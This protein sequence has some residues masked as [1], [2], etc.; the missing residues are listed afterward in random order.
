VTGGPRDP[1]ASVRERLRQRLKDV[2]R[3]HAAL[4][5]AILAAFVALSA[6]VV[7]RMQAD[8]D[9]QLTSYD[10][11]AGQAIPGLR[12]KGPI[13]RE[14][15]GFI[16]PSPATAR[17]S[18]P[19]ST[20]APPEGTRTLLL[21][22]AGG[23][24]GSSTTLS[25]IDAAGVSHRL[26]SPLRWH[27]RHVDVTQLL[28]GGGIERL[29]FV[30]R[31]RTP[32]FQQMVLQ[33]R[34][35]SYSPS[36]VPSASRWEIG[37]WVALALAAALALVGR[38]RRD[39]V[40]PVLAGLTAFLVWP[41][42]EAGVFQQVPSDLWPSAVHAGW[43]DLDT[44]LLSG[45]FGLRSSLA[46]QLFHALTPLTGTGS[47]GARTA[48]M[49]VGVLAIVAIYA[50]GRRV[51]GPLGAVTAVTCAL[52]TDA[53]RMSLSAGNSTGALVLAACVFLIA[54]HRVLLRPDRTAM[55]LLG[56]AG[57][58]AILAEPTWWPGVV[59][60]V[61]ILALRYSPRGAARA[62]LVAAL[63]TL[64]LVSLP[65]R[66]SVAR[67]S[68][69][70]VN[71][72]VIGR[73]TVARNVEFLGRGHGAPPDRNALLADP[74]G[75][76]KVGLFDYVFG[77]HSLS[78]VGGS[79]LSGAYDGISSTADR[80]ETPFL[81][82]VAFIAELLGVALLLLVP[83][84]RMLAIVPALLALAQWFF[85]GRGAGDQFPAHAAFWPAMLAGAA[86]LAYAV[87]EIARER[88]ASRGVGAGVRSRAWA[89]G[90]RGARR[91]EPAKP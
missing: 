82:L 79:V 32:E 1:A 39:A 44:G 13:L 81:S 35:A 51:A 24:P 6:V 19:I 52:L 90:R 61:V 8:G 26:G 42:V 18:I 77:E 66:V 47:V 91:A 43:I 71:A 78:V 20:S 72:D 54:V 37:L 46:V 38:L 80:T 60:A 2:D 65:S 34:V 21:V 62:G 64:V 17:A 30:A 83:G 33:V 55:L 31:N 27:E 70:D 45:T 10:F 3:R 73:T 5:L 4:V 41:S 74:S 9:V 85:L 53:F 40:L 57:A 69:G 88:L 59:A 68:D 58:V 86:A 75:G 50:L 49:L 84:L 12:T 7:P 23:N 63:L 36:A 15:Y 76:P 25:L 29:Q 48:S 28:A 16:V 22:T 11:V 89:L 67:Q 56:A 14:P 87:R